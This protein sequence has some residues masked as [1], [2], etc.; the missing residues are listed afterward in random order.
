M[1]ETASGLATRR[2]AGNASVNPIAVWAGA[3]GRFV[4]VNVS[5]DGT[6]VPVE[7]G[8]N[9]FVSAAFRV[10]E[11]VQVTF[12][13]GVTSAAARLTVAPAAAPTAETPSVQATLASVQPPGTVWEI[14]TGAPFADILAE[15]QR[16]GYAEA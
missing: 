13:P 10:S 12:L 9:A 4:T 5:V 7:L 16:R 3:P 14:E 2:P 1:L 6:P 11:N 15:A 8:A